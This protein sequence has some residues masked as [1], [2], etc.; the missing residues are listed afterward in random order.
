[1]IL[2]PL[3]TREQRT[4]LRQGRA[5][6]WPPCLSLN[7]S[8][9]DNTVL[10]NS[11]RNLPLHVVAGATHGRLCPPKQTQSAIGGSFNTHTPSIAA[12]V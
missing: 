11:R 4:W 5:E 1:M 12:A 3:L 9:F 2:G 6:V 10:K 7:K 8:S